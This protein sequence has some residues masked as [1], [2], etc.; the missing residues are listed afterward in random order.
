MFSMSFFNWI[1]SDSTSVISPWIVLFFGTT[2]TVT[3]LL[4]WHSKNRI[5]KEDMEIEE[6][7]RKQLGSDQGSVA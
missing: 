2:V 4:Y 1:P 7:L 3:G 5:V 6:W